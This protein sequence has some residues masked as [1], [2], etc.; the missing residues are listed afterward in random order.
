MPIVCIKC[1]LSCVQLVLVRVQEEDL[2]VEQRG[3]EESSGRNHLAHWKTGRCSHRAAWRYTN[4]SCEC[5]LG[6]NL[7]EVWWCLLYLQGLAEVA[8]QCFCELAVALSHF[9]FRSNI[10]AV[11]VPRMN[12][13]ALQGKVC[14]YCLALNAGD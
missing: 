11:I 2:G 14:C 8:L 13:K 5:Y 1:N 7:M 6:R 3:K 12:S 4:Q 9:N 10:F